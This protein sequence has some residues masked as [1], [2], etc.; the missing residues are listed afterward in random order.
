[1]TGSFSFLLVEEILEEET[2]GEG[3]KSVVAMEGEVQVTTVARP[4]PFPLVQANALKEVVVAAPAPQVV[5]H[6]SRPN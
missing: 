6:L 1:M 5:P 2:M 4:A 3:D